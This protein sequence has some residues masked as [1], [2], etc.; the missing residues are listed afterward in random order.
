MVVWKSLAGDVSQG[1][2]AAGPSAGLPVPKP[3]APHQPSTGHLLFVVAMNSGSS[4]ARRSKAK[5]S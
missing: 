2:L 3:A 5:K 1:R 4:W